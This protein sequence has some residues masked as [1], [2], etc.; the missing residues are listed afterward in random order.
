LR[1][2]KY[3][4][5]CALGERRAAVSQA[6]GPPYE[7]YRAELYPPQELFDGFDPVEPESYAATLEARIYAHA[8]STGKFAPSSCLEA[9]TRHLHDHAI[10]DARQYIAPY[11]ETRIV[12]IMG[13]HA[14]KR[15]SASYR[16]VLKIGQALTRN[17]CLPVTGGAPGA[18]ETIHLG[19]RMACHDEPRL[20]QAIARMRA[21]V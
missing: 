10:A 19:A 16:E 17:D 5:S 14:L 2:V 18:M 4:Q 3:N 15:T 21:N 9:L 12:G 13:G 1:N 7:P 11:D 8:V 20:M 6:A